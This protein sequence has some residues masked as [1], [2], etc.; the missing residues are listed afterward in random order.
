MKKKPLKV[1]FLKTLVKFL[2]PLSLLAE[3]LLEVGKHRL[4]GRLFLIRVCPF[5][6][7][8]ANLVFTRLSPLSPKLF[9]RLEI[10]YY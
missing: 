5:L 4:N 1:I 9:Q 8:P 10:K 6:S 7:F 2:S 3:S